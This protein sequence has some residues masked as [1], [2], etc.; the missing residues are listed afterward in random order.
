MSGM[1][2][3]PHWQLKPDGIGMTDERRRTAGGADCGR[4]PAFRHP[5]SVT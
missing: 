4:Q 2:W 3:V 1:G 5:S